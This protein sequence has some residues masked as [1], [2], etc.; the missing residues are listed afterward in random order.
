MVAELSDADELRNR[1]D[2]ANIRFSQFCESA[3]H[4]NVSIRKVLR[5]L[6]LQSDEGC[7]HRS[8][9][10]DCPKG[11]YE[12]NYFAQVGLMQTTVMN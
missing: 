10:K 5:T 11:K 9:E 2:E 3:K 4:P 1:H 12:L 7:G 6:N 8:S